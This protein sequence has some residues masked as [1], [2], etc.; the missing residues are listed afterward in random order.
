[1][2]DNT[3]KR[4]QIRLHADSTEANPQLPNKPPYL[5][6]GTDFSVELRSSIPSD[7]NRLLAAVKELIPSHGQVADRLFRELAGYEAGML[8]WIERS[9]VNAEWFAASPLEAI[10]GAPIGIP[11][12]LLAELKAF[13]SALSAMTNKVKGGK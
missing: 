3:S 12:E 9:P 7:H 8:D 5:F 13:L 11:K 6:G 10:E 4:I 1:M 2:K